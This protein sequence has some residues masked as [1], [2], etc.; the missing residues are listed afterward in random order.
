M[1]VEEVVGEVITHFVV[2]GLLMFVKDG[3]NWGYGV[4]RSPF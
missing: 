3:W 1:D 4:R 2:L